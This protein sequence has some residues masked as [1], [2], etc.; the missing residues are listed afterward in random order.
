MKDIFTEANN[1][2]LNQCSNMVRIKSAMKECQDL[3]W[4]AVAPIHY[5][6]QQEFLKVYDYYEE[7]NLMK[8]TAKGL[9]NTVKKEFDRYQEYMSAN[10]TP[11]AYAVPFDLCNQIYGGL[12][13]EILDLNLTFKFYMERKGMKNIDIKAQVQTV[14]V[15]FDCWK[16]IWETFF[17]KYK[18]EYYINFE[19]YYYFANLYNAEKTFHRFYVDVIKPERYDGFVPAK[20]YPSVMAFNAFADK[21]TNDDF[22]DEKAIASLCMNN[23]VEE[24]A[25]I[26][27]GDTGIMQNAKIIRKS[28]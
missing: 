18:K 25:E 28:S 11:D 16:S 17:D 23:R 27:D 7:N 20:N 8:F 13:K 1:V 4:A 21:I 12:E 5:V 10:Y 15:M 22:V 19:G 24:L 6:A 2:A 26:F 9:L 3:F 14:Q